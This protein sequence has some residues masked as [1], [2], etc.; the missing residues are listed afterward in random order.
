MSSVPWYTDFIG[1]AYR[2]FDLRMNIIPLFT[3][4]EQSL[5][6]WQDTI[7]WWVNPSI[8]VRFVES[9]DDYWFILGADSQKPDTNYAFYKTLPKSVHYERFKKGHGGEAY[10]RFGVYKKVYLVDAKKNTICECGHEAVDHDEGDNDVCLYNTCECKKFETF[11]INML[12][13]KKTV[14]D[15]DFLDEDSVKDDVLAWNCL[16]KHKYSNQS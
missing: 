12:K 8:K 7:H 16:Y 13:R 2:Y 3:S 1:I 14:T 10:L 6:L 11:Q 4:Q 15:I 5:P 9:N